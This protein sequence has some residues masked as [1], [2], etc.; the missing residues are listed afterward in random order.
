MG[1]KRHAPLDLQKFNKNGWF[2]GRYLSHT[3]AHKQRASI[4]TS[5]PLSAPV[6]STGHSE[7][8]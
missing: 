3:H 6:P 7:V 2:I 8:T 4:L 1:S 5:D